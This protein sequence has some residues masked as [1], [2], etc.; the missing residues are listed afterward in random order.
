[1]TL[2]PE[3]ALCSHGDVGQFGNEEALRGLALDG[4]PAPIIALGRRHIRMP[5][6]ALHGRDV[7]AGIQQVADRTASSNGAGS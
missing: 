1:M 6:Q 7:G 4:F 2:S 5:R 3:D